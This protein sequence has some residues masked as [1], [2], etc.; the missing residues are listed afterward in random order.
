MELTGWVESVR[1]HVQD[2]AVF[3]VPLQ[4]GTGTRLKI[5][6]HFESTGSTVTQGEVH[7]VRRIA[8]YKKIR[9]YTHENICY[10]NIN[11]PDQE[12]HTTAAWWQLDPDALDDAAVNLP[13][14]VP[15]PDFDD[16]RVGAFTTI[17]AL[18]SRPGIDE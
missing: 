3:V 4:L 7:L 5:L 16:D 14:G 9:Y 6:E 18:Q 1:D 10:G 15:A 17:V 13:P 12:M 11:L 2:A 8:G